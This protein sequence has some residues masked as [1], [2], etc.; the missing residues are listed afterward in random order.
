M[1]SIQIGLK[2]SK[3]VTT[4][5]R[6]IYQRRARSTWKK[7]HLKSFSACKRDAYCDGFL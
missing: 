3:I 1:H 2:V 6:S 4:I 5:V 7:R